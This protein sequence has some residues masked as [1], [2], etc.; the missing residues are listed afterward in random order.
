[1]TTPGRIASVVAGLLLLICPAL[2]GQTSLSGP[3]L[4]FVFS[5]AEERLRP[6]RGVLGSATVG[7]PVELGMPIT[8]ALTMDMRHVVASSEAN[9]ELLL[10]NLETSPAAVA[11]ISSTIKVSAFV[12]CASSTQWCFSRLLNCGSSS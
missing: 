8:D 1:M 4:G 12:C 6:V 7:D 9:A 11:A 5:A 10:L 2:A 3:I